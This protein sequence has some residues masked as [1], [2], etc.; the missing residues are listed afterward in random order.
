L[1]TGHIDRGWGFKPTWKRKSMSIDGG[2][3]KKEEKLSK[4]TNLECNEL[5]QM[6]HLAQCSTEQFLPLLEEA[7]ARVL[8]LSF[9]S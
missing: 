1:H 8:T 2:G 6:K 4:I 7:Q 9:S 3:S 5:R